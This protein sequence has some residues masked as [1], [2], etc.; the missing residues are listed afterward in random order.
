MWLKVDLAWR[1]RLR[2]IRKG[3]TLGL[4]LVQHQPT[5]ASSGLEESAAAK[6]LMIGSAQSTGTSDHDDCDPGAGKLPDS[7]VCSDEC[8]DGIS[9]AWLFEEKVEEEPFDTPSPHL[10]WLQKETLLTLDDIPPFSEGNCPTQRMPGAF[11]D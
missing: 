3:T 5:A 2:G 6:V 4:I 10:D 1:R 7:I 9:V 8:I 11:G